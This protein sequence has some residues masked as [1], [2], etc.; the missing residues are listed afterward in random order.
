VRTSRTAWRTTARTVRSS[1]A[2]N[3][4]WASLGSHK[5]SADSYRSEFAF[6]A[7]LNTQALLR[8]VDRYL[9]A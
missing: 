3:P 9:Y 8:L 6:A 1:R 7:L 5:A 2:F 4:L